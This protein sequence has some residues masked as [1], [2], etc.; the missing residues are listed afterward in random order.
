MKNH[1]ECLHSGKCCEKVYTQ[2]NLTAGDVVRLAKFLDWRAEDFVSK[3]II[4]LKPFLI[5]DNIVEVE[6]GLTIPCKFRENKKC[7]VYE[8]RPLNCRLFPY[9][10]FADVPEQKIGEFVDESYE[11]VRKV[12]LTKQTKERYVEYKEF[13]ASIL[14]IESTA[15]DE[16]M[17]SKG[18][19]YTI[20]ISKHDGFEN[21]QDKIERLKRSYSGV[22][23]HKKSDEI[24]LDFA[25]TLINKANLNVTEAVKRFI[26]M[27]V[28]TLDYLNKRESEILN[29][30]KD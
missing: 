25:F 2:I 21:V 7:A 5:S 12:K 24:K 8:A 29:S 19:M 26:E 1:F 13:V 3:G 4:G 30:F 28:S 23:L 14:E 22:E 18:L 15:T 9:W 16:L 17:A 27:K 10:I 11:C 6:L 20:D